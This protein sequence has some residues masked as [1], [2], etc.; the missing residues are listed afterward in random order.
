MRAPRPATVTGSGSGAAEAGERFVASRFALEV[1]S[2]ETSPPIL[3]AA[4][5]M[6]G[7]LGATEAAE[8]L[9]ALLASGPAL[10]A[11]EHDEDEVPHVHTEKEMRAL[12]DR[13]K[14][15]TR[16]QAALGLG[17]MGASGSS[18]VLLR[19]AMDPD[20]PVRVRVHATLSL[21][22]LRQAAAVGPVLRVL[23]RDD[24]PEVHLAAATALGLIGDAAAAEELG[25]RL[26]NLGTRDEVR[27]AAAT[28]LGK[29]GDVRIG[30][31]TAGALLAA[32]LLRDRDADVRRSAALVMHR[33]AGAEAIAALGQA[34]WGDRDAPTR[35]FALLSLARATA[36]GSG[37][38]ARERCRLHAARVLRAGDDRESGFGAL[39]LGLLARAGERS[40]LPALREA[41]AGSRSENTR[42]AVVVALGLARDPESRAAIAEIVRRAPGTATADGGEE[43]AGRSLR[44]KVLGGG[45]GPDP[46][47]RYSAKVRAYACIALGLFESADAVAS[48]ALR[49]A[50]GDGNDPA[51]RGAAAIGLSGLGDRSGTPALTALLRGKSAFL[52]N[53]VVIALGFYRDL[54][55][56]RDLLDHYYRE[57]DPVLRAAAVSAIGTIADPSRPP[58]LLR[59]ASDF[60]PLLV[61]GRFSALERALR[62][63]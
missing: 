13:V 48:A 34:A 2:R 29:L 9:E 4:A 31:T 14:S 49:E 37:L 51:I 42:A 46:G 30:E 47:P 20:A 17:L 50:L 6:A 8:K 56:T 27:A 36:A 35:G 24:E 61:M 28:A 16:E 5:I 25:R 55:A 19:I 58:L 10:S 45:A 1:L 57:K 54:D 63:Y 21:G 59:I 38:E 43:R 40:A 7:K 18:P 3:G 32:A 26:S 62:L 39:A 60:N 11:H 22:L 53:S 12:A 41:L 52:R 44:A 33:V 15:E 23:G